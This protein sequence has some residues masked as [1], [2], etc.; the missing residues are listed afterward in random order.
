MRAADRLPHALGVLHDRL[1]LGD[2]LVDQPADAKLVVGVR[3]L[4]RGDFV[5]NE[6]L[7]LTGARERP[8]DAVAH[9]RHLAADC[10]ADGDDGFLR[11][12]LWLGKSQRHLR[13][14]A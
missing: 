9:R 3:A 6:H 12:V 2:E 7:K 1:A 5:V 10:L 8:L 13:H 14:R 4:E 11:D